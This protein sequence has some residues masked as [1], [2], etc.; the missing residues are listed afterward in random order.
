MT[1]YEVMWLIVGMAVGANLARTA[2]IIGM[3]IRRK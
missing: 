2:H 1:Q 3:M